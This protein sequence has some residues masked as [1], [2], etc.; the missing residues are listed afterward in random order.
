MTEQRRC[1]RTCVITLRSQLTGHVGYGGSRHRVQ[2][3]CVQAICVYAPMCLWNCVQAICTII[4]GPPGAVP[5]QRVTWA[6]AVGLGD[7]QAP[8]DSYY[9]K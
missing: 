7:A 6:R 9:T 2:A 4:L 1:D 5:A 8:P 3:I